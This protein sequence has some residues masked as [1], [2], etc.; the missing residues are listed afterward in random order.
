MNTAS[1]IL[2]S[3]SY[4]RHGAFNDHSVAWGDTFRAL[5]GESCNISPSWRYGLPVG[6]LFMEVVGTPEALAFVE[7]SVAV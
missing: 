7:N 3:E 4:V 5:G 1:Y 2:D 6:D